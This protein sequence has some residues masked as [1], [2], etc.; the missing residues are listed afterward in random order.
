MGRSVMET[1]FTYCAK[2][3]GRALL[4]P[5]Q[6]IVRAGLSW[7]PEAGSKF[8]LSWVVKL[9]KHFFYILRKRG[10]LG[11]A[12]LELRPTPQLIFRRTGSDL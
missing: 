1:F 9:L 4:V 10:S 3:V 2:E 7:G 5:E 6:S 8:E 11:R 12:A